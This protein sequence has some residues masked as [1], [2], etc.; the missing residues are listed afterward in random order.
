VN[1]RAF[2]LEAQQRWRRLW[3]RE[4]LASPRVPEWV[5]LSPSIGDLAAYEYARLALSWSGWEDKSAP[6]GW[7]AEVRAKLGALLG[8]TL[9]PVKNSRSFQGA[10]EK[11][12]QDIRR[13]TTY[14]PTALGR[15][16]AV[17]MVWSARRARERLPIMLCM[18]GHT[19]GA[20]ISWG[21]ARHPMDIQRIKNGGD[22]ALQAV[23]NGFVAAC[24]E[25]LC[26]GERGEREVA[27]RWDH[28]CVDA[29]NRQLL[30][31]GTVLGARVADLS[32]VID[33]LQS[34]DFV[35]AHID[36]SRVYAMGN[37]AGGESALFAMAMD[38]RISGAMVSGCVGNWRETSGRR[39]TCP[40][41]VVPGVLNWFEYSDVIGLCAPRGLVVVSGRKDHIYPF[42]LARKCVQDAAEIFAACNAQ[43]RLI[44]LEGAAGHQFYPE[45]SWPHFLQMLEHNS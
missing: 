43:D 9:P 23:E 45:L 15:H 30:M 18:Q 2:L 6:L 42:G 17:T 21:E 19:S 39:R 11:V 3:G 27:H 16:T 1:I 7:Q 38:C 13:K 8:D 26:F 4:D 20:H 25:Q 22:Y 31:G 5:E 40:D 44:A 10:Q 41:T 24:V 29:C 28:P 37:S 14:I 34:G 12:T 33:W 36:A 32:Q 35:G